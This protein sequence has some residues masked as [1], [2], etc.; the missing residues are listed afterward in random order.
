MFIFARVVGSNF[1]LLLFLMY[2]GGLRFQHICTCDIYVFGP[3]LF[4]C[5]VTRTVLMLHLS[6]IASAYVVVRAFC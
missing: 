6:Q 4:G 1:T 2:L 3:C 5:P